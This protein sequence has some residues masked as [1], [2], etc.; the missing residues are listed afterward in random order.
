MTMASGGPPSASRRPVPRHGRGRRAGPAD[1]AGRPRTRRRRRRSRPPRV[2]V[3]TAPP[4][5]R[6]A[7]PSRPPSSPSGSARRRGRTRRWRSTAATCSEGR[8][9]GSRGSRPTGTCSRAWR[10]APTGYRWGRWT[11]RCTSCS[12]C[13]RPPPGAR[14]RTPGRG[15]GL[16]YQRVAKAEAEGRGGVGAVVGPAAEFP[17]SLLFG[18]NFLPS[19]NCLEFSATFCPYL[20]VV[21]VAPENPI[22]RRQRWP[23]ASR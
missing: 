17:V 22:I 8:R 15:G 21:E 1:D 7:S 13:A 14:P 19:R 18:E 6:R 3:G 4:D 5:N 20:E 11:R 2:G 10:T 12:C 9:A 23:S 16:L